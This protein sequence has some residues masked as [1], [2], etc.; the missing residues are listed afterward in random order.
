MAAGGRDSRDGSA[1][2]VASALGNGRAAGVLLHVTSLPSAHG[3]GDLGPAAYAWIDRLHDAGQRWWQ[4]LPLGPTGYENSPYQTLSSFAGNVL[5]LSPEALRDE[6]L[7]PSDSGH[8]QAYPERVIDYEVVIPCRRH[9]IAKAWAQF[10]RAA[11]SEL[12]MAYDE[13]RHAQVHWL[14]DYALFQA[15]KARYQ[16]AHYLTWAPALVQRVPAALAAAR[17][18]LVRPIDEVCLGQFLLARQGE[19]LRAYAHRNGVRLIGDLPFFVSGDSSD[20]W[21]SPELFLLDDRRRPRWVAGV[22]PDAFSADGQLWGN[23]VYDWEVHR[24][25]GYRWWIDRLRALLAHVDAVRLDHF[26]GFAAAWHVPA[27]APDARA[28]TWAPGPGAALFSAVREALG[29]LPV[30]AEDLGRITPDVAALRDQ[31]G[32]PGT[33]VL[34]FA[35]DGTPDNPHLP[36]HC[37]PRTV[38]YTGTHDNDTT[39]GWFAASPEDRRQRV[40]EYLQ[41]PQMREADIS[42]AFIE[43]AWRSQA[44][45]AIAPFQDV[46]NLG[47]EARM[48]VPG[49]ASGNWR[50]RC[51]SEQLATPALEWLGD[52]TT[53]A[54]RSAADP[55]AACTHLTHAPDHRAG[56]RA[57]RPGASGVRGGDTGPS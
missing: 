37:G 14:A 56:S 11:P 30:L 2:A 32:I 34:Q 49:R 9:L 21:A 17:R 43:L 8:G 1:V 23:P 24:R 52:L 53:A 6:G 51:T 18:E 13:F 54:G 16:G 40:R 5:L 46:L 39:R 22:P 4:S 19:R 44:S 48:N 28:G 27:G 38:V 33:R 7:L 20:V 25:S 10:Q 29:G 47:S 3:I 41:R 15:L 45:L 50:W 55:S 12:R 42:G 35:F 26:R 31:F 36:E 57:A